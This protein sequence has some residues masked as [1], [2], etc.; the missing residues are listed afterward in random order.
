MYLAVANDDKDYAENIMS[1]IF[2]VNV[3]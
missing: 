3:K 1:R 2:K